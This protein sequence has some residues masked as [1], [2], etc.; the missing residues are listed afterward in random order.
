MYFGQMDCDKSGSGNK[1]RQTYASVVRGS[2]G[3]KG[4]LTDTCWRKFQ[5]EDEDEAIAVATKNSISAMEKVL[6][7][8]YS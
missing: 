3:K 4:A 1:P 6:Y 8:I 7:L 2:G 5:L